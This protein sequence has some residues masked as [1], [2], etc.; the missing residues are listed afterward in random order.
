MSNIYC[1]HAWIRH[2]AIVRFISI[3]AVSFLAA[4]CA[5]QVV[6][7]EE[8]SG[9]LRD[10]SDFVEMEASDGV[11]MLGWESPELANRKISALLLDPVTIYPAPKANPRVPRDVITEILDYYNSQL[12]AKVG[13]EVQLT[14]KPG[15]NVGRVRLAI[16]HI[17]SG[18]QSLRWYNYTPIS[19]TIAGIGEATGV[20]D[21]TVQL[22]AEVELLDS[23]T[24]ERLAAG[25]RL[26]S[27]ENIDVDAPIDFEH[28]QPIIDE[29]VA[30]TVTWVRREMQ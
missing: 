28:M 18:F 17:D 11:E 9:F 24:S 29:W 22:I 19:M 30:S 20:R 5:Q 4:G 7:Q 16:T 14:D 8:F 15:P 26:G 23:Q 10:Y 21:E 6:K 3:A 27:G 25:I 12:R 13:A 2:P 1:G